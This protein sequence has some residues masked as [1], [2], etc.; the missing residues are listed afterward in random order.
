MYLFFVRNDKY[1]QTLLKN[2]RIISIRECG[3]W[4]NI[5][6]YLNIFGQTTIF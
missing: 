1:K 4:Y 6:S 5:G 3:Q 2:V